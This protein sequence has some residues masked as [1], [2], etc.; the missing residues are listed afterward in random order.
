MGSQKCR[1]VGKS[2]SVLMMID[3]MIFTRTHIGVAVAR[4]GVDAVC[5]LGYTRD[6]SAPAAVSAGAASRCR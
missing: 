2:Q 6:K 4:L 3:P 1:L 5:T